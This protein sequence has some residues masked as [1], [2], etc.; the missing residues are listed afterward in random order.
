VP[1]NRRKSTSGK[2]ND[3]VDALLIFAA[4]VAVSSVFVEL[5]GWQ[6]LHEQSPQGWWALEAFEL[7]CVTTDASAGLAVIM[8]VLVV[9]RGVICGLVRTEDE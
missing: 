8:L 9:M 1:T 2:K 7:G 6:V 4:A 3:E 5:V